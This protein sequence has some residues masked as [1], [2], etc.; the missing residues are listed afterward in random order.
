MWWLALILLLV[1]IGIL[2]MGAE[3]LVRGAASAARRMG[4][5]TLVV[6]MTVIA[7]GTSTPE[8]VVSLRAALSGSTDLALGNMM[9]SNIANVGLVLGL[10]ALV[11]PVTCNSKFVSREVVTMLIVTGVFCVTLWDQALG[12]TE[13]LVLLVVFG[14]LMWVT[15]K[16]NRTGQGEEAIPGL[17]E[18]IEKTHGV[19][20]QDDAVERGVNGWLRDAAFIVVGIGLLVFGGE[21]VVGN[22]KSLATH[23][24]VSGRVVGLTVVAI[25]TSLPELMVSLTAAFRRHPDMVLGNVIGSNIY[26]LAVVGG[27]T[28]AIAPPLSSAQ[29]IWLDMLVMLV[30]SLACLPIVMSGGRITRWEGAALCVVYVGYMVFLC[31]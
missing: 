30:L 28:A 23:W 10:T 9:G 5:S 19:E 29:S 11:Y 2:M 17:D 21:V 12:R 18:E 24:G 3:V 25:G 20:T 31:L 4:I 8:L 26:N 13:G 16:R 15:F 6:G 27:T 14:G 7:F 22:A 1:G